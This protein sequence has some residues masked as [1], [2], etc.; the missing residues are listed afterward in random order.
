LGIFLKCLEDT[1]EEACDAGGVYVVLQNQRWVLQYY[2]NNLC[3]C[4]VTYPL[5]ECLD[6]VYAVFP[7]DDRTTARR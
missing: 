5:T 3:I 4:W 1:S 7:G 6:P 2:M